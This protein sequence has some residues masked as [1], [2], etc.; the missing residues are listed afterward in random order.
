[1]KVVHVFGKQSTSLIVGQ[2][3]NRD[4]WH[5]V[6]VRIDVHGAKLIARVDDKQ[7]ETTL[8][9]LERIVNYG[10]SEELASVVLIG[11][12]PSY[13]KSLSP[14]RI[15]FFLHLYRFNF[16]STGL[17]SEERLHGVK[18]IIESFVGCI[19]DMVLSSGKSASDLLPIR[20]LIATKH[21]NVKE[22]CIDKYVSFLEKKEGSVYIK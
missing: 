8:K 4:E 2:G 13:E 9:V 15:F 14:R 6:L 10:V 12:E 17:S 22:G 7:A 21:E 18:Y 11:G 19:R 1:M 16:V 20:P 5:S 3:L